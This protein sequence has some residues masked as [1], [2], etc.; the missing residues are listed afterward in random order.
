ML[1]DATTLRP[2]VKEL[3]KKFAASNMSYLNNRRCSL[4]S[5]LFSHI[6]K[7]SVFYYFILSLHSGYK[8]TKTMIESTPR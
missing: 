2:T 8:K 4:V 3:T 5:Y 1:F 6:S 7:D